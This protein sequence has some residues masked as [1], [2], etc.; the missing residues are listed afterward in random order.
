MHYHADEGE[1][2]NMARTGLL[3]VL[4]AAL[5]APAALAAQGR[6]VTAVATVTQLC[7]G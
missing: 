4:V 2:R 3:L 7:Q 6:T 5:A 1:K